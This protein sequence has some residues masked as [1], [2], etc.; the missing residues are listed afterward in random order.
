MVADCWFEEGWT[1]GTGVELQTDFA[2]AVVV[3][4]GVLLQTAGRGVWPSVNF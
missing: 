4:G 1:F 3:V 2:A